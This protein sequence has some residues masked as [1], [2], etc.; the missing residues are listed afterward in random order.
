MVCLGLFAAGVQLRACLLSL[1]TSMV[2]LSSLLVAGSL[3][4]VLR[5]GLK[6]TSDI[7]KSAGLREM[8]RVHSRK[9]MCRR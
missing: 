1:P 3:C 6:T 2:R 8:A 7:C 4:L 5:A 9:S